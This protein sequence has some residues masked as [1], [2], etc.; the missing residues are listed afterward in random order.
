MKCLLY[1][2]KIHVVTIIFDKLPNC[3][4]LITYIY[5]ITFVANFTVK[6]NEKFFSCRHSLLL[7]CI[8]PLIF[9]IWRLDIHILW[10]PKIWNVFSERKTKCVSKTDPRGWKRKGESRH[11]KRGRVLAA[12]NFNDKQGVVISRCFSP[13]LPRTASGEPP[14]RDCINSSRSLRPGFPFTPHSLFCSA[15]SSHLTLLLLDP[16]VDVTRHP[17]RSTTSGDKRSVSASRIM[18]RARSFPRHFLVTRFRVPRE[19]VRVGT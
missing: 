3:P 1:I 12:Y 16:R 14:P 5:M 15:S 9:S 11:G 18:K 4:K 10:L 8:W 17:S 19:D 6:K 2:S 13:S 7:M